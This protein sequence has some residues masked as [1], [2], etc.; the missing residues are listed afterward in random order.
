M[1]NSWI[2]KCFKFCVNKVI[3]IYFNFRWFQA[4]PWGLAGKGNWGWQQQK[5]HCDYERRTVWRVRLQRQWEWGNQ[6]VFTHYWSCKSNNN[7]R[8]SQEKNAS[9]E[10]QV[11]IANSRYVLYFLFMIRVAR[12]GCFL[13]ECIN[14]SWLWIHLIFYAYTSFCT[15]KIFLKSVNIRYAIFFVQKFE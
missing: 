11:Y 6:R 12:K 10:D 14:F 15:Q 7:T 2:M 3:S 8:K 5:C 13:S 9:Q 1:I 4:S